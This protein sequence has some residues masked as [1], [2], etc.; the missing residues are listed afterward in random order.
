MERLSVSQLYYLSLHTIHTKLMDHKLDLQ[1]LPQFLCRSLVSSK[2]LHVPII[3]F[4]KLRPVSELNLQSSG[5][6]FTY[7][8]FLS[9]LK[10]SFLVEPEDGHLTLKLV[11][12]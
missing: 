11:T 12:N 6:K 1:L 4:I 2:N 10:R 3:I 7:F 5:S 9:C 8:F